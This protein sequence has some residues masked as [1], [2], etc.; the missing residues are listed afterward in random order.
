[1]F[2]VKS[3]MITLSEKLILDCSKGIS[4]VARILKNGLGPPNLCAVLHHASK[5][6]IVLK[7]GTGFGL[8]V[9]VYYFSVFSVSGKLEMGWFLTVILLI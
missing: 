5:Q 6:K 9:R 1:M 3:E 4:K 7:S 2:Y 8:L